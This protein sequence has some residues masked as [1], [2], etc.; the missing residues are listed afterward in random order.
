MKVKQKLK[1]QGSDGYNQYTTKILM[2]Q[3]QD[4]NK[5]HIKPTVE[6]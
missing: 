2:Q 4:S 3:R 5:I 1:A 6:E